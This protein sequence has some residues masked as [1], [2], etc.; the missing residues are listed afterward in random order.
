MA[1]KPGTAVARREQISKT[2]RRVAQVLARPGR[3]QAGCALA[4]SCAKGLYPGT[5]QARIAGTALVSARRKRQGRDLEMERRNASHRYARFGR[6][7]AVA[8]HI[9]PNPGPLLSAGGTGQGR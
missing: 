7:A 3:V 8:A 9:G 5:P 1:P 4:P 2:C 6:R